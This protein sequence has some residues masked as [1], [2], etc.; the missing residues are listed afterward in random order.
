[1]IQAGYATFSEWEKVAAEMDILMENTEAVFYYNPMQAT[2][3]I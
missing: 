3:K 2:A 1:M